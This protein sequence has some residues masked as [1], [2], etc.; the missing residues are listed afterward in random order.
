M[1]DTGAPLMPPLDV[2][3]AARRSGVGLSPGPI[4]LQIRFIFVARPFLLLRALFWGALAG[5]LWRARRGV[6]LLW[7]SGTG[8]KR[9]P[10]PPLPPPAPPWPQPM[11]RAWPAGPVA[12]TVAAVPE[13]IHR[14]LTRGP[15]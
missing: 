3:K 14:S 6:L 10:A 4:S 7:R 15:A 11:R 13:T 1:T 5:L 9:R 8:R 12:G 2:L